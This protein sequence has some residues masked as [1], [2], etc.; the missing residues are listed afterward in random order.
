MI[1]FE[2]GARYLDEYFMIFLL[3]N[4]R[5]ETVRGCC[6][7]E[8]VR[9]KENIDFSSKKRAAPLAERKV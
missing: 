5:G 8:Q 6:S 4:E 7:L 1:I 2:S 9:Q 3:R